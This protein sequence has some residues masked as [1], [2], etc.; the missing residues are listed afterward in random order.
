M[1]IPRNAVNL[2]VIP[3]NDLMTS[4]DESLVPKRSTDTG[5]NFDLSRNANAHSL[6][7]NVRYDQ[8]RGEERSAI[9]Q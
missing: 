6:F 3:F 2:G 4:S 9:R 7:S 5:A 8:R 1:S